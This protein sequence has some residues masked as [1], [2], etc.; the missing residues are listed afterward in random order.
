VQ[1]KRA[2]S[3]KARPG[4]RQL[5]EATRGG[6]S[7]SIPYLRAE[8]GARVREG[9]EKAQIGL[10]AKGGGE[11]KREREFMEMRGGKKI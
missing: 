7:A 1:R 2:T 5:S 9:G 8:R 3:R 4:E 11:K 10:P 6:D